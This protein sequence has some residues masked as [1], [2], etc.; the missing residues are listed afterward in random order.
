M[1]GEIQNHR[2]KQC[3][4]TP[5]PQDDQHVART[6]SRG[7]GRYP[8]RT[9]TTSATP[10]FLDM[11]FVFSTVTLILSTCQ[12]LPAFLVSGA[13]PAEL[14]HTTDSNLDNGQKDSSTLMRNNADN[15]GDNP[16]SA[17]TD[18]DK[19]NNDN[20]P[21]KRL[22]D[23]NEDTTILIRRTDPNNFG[24]SP[25]NDNNNNNNNDD[26]NDNNDSSNRRLYHICAA[27]D[28]T[29][30]PMYEDHYTSSLAATSEPTTNFHMTNEMRVRLL[31]GD[32]VDGDLSVETQ[33]DLESAILQ[34]SNDMMGA[35]G[36]GG[37]IEFDAIVITEFVEADV[38]VMGRGRSFEAS[39]R[40]NSIG[41]CTS[42]CPLYFP[43]EDNGNARRVLFEKS[44]STQKRIQSNAIS[45]WDLYQQY[46]RQISGNAGADD[47]DEESDLNFDTY[48]ASV[49]R[50][51]FGFSTVFTA[52][53]VQSTPIDCSIY[54]KDCRVPSEDADISDYPCCGA[55]AGCECQ[56]VSESLCVLNGCAIGGG[57][58]CEVFDDD[59]SPVYPPCEGTEYCEAI[60]NITFF[61]T[62]ESDFDGICG[63]AG[64]YCWLSF[65]SLNKFVAGVDCLYC[66]LHHG[67]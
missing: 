10:S 37:V 33:T 45:S 20:D 40:F 38:C 25:D 53:L 43:S 55:D 39:I 48:F 26:E 17:D 35:T 15:F 61:E 21:L 7:R 63:D 24:N 50:D 52:Q 49:I 67:R 34:Y 23:N 3:C 1:T 6:A 31:C 9:T 56:F 51:Q 65:F 22:L 66:P 59:G 60:R 11:F 28:F 62:F 42:S 41:R 12:Y 2:R 16:W 46:R 44:A 32:V 8:P 57:L 14:P 64:E 4:R 5:A 29:Y 13:L 27:S 18:N 58:C 30:A 36:C 47:D 19:N 54:S